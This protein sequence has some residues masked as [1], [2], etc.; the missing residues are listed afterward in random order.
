MIFI[1][2][3]LFIINVVLTFLSMGDNVNTKQV[4]FNRIVNNV[5]GFPFEQFKDGFPLLQSNT[6]F[7]TLK[8]LIFLFLNTLIQAIG[9]NLIGNIIKR[10]KTNE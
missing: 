4:E 9:I 3:G 10:R 6:D 2:I 7:W 1:L 8:N 5:V